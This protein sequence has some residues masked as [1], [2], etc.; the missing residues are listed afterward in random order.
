MTQGSRS[1]R[2]NQRPQGSGSGNG[3]GRGRGA[4][5]AGRSNSNPRSASERGGESTSGSW[6][7][8]HGGPKQ[9]KKPGTGSGAKKYTGP[10]AFGKERFG[11]NLGPVK[12]DRPNKPTQRERAQ[13][14]HSD[15]EGVRL[16]KVMANAGVASR[17]VCE[18]MIAGG[19]VEVNGAL[20]V[21]PGVRIDPERDT[22]HVDG[23]RLQLN[24]EMKYFV[25]NKPR[26]V[27]ST[28]EDPEGRKCISDFI[29]KKGQERLFHVGRL[30]Y[31]T[32]GLLILTNDGEMANRL[33]HPSYEVPKTYLVQVRGP[34]ANGVGAQMKK[35]IKLED[36][37]ASVDSFRLIDSTPGYLL[38]EVVLHSGRNRIVRRLFDA[39]GHPVT[40]L[41][42][43][44]VGP[45]RLG[46][47]KQGTIR[48]LG[49][50]EVGHLLALVG[51]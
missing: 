30:D 20:V 13:A 29:R 32:E 37:W 10:K 27:V 31:Q 16:Q 18:E 39:V 23:M 17:R 40:R 2:G 15:L 48:P 5:G 36:G 33:S 12:A 21:E 34:M 49:N 44:Q 22:V 6:S 35:G 41:V 4:A 47:Q 26:N 24:E 7:K 38:I 42:R 51:M 19:R 8:T 14:A 28:M 1:S 50:Q 45:I 25:F 3:N 46:D 43:V 11:Q 9:G